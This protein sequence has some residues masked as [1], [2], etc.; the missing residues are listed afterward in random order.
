MGVHLQQ[1]DGSAPTWGLPDNFRVDPLE[2]V[3]PGIAAR[4]EENHHG[5]AVG[6]NPGQIRAFVQ[7]A[8]VA[9]QREIR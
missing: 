7:I 9:S 4:M 3:V 1:S 5:T 6:I 2:V 8:S